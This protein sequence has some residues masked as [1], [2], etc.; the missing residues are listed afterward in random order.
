[1]APWKRVRALAFTAALVCAA[2][3]SADAALLLITPS[4][5]HR[6]I[7]GFL[8]GT[9]DALQFDPGVNTVTITMSQEERLAMEFALAGLPADAIIISATLG[10][11]SPFLPLAANTI[12]IHGYA[13][14]GTVQVTDLNTT[15]FVTTFGFN[16]LSVDV[17]IPVAFL[18]GLVDGD[19]DYAGLVLRNVTAPFGVAQFYSID[20]GNPAVHPT[21]AIEYESM[22]VVPEPASLVLLGTALVA[23]AHRVRRRRAQRGR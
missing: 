2:P 20:W 17:P 18:Q 15:N 14:D 8:D 6:G 22:E 13:G 7:D 19:E 23:C 4:D 1:M 9:F 11:E 21:L 16:A 10:L 3:V 12:D 5:D